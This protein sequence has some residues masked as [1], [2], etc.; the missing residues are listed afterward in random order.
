MLHFVALLWQKADPAKCE[1]AQRLLRRFQAR[2]P[3]WRLACHA[4]GLAALFTITGGPTVDQPYLLPDHVGVVFGRLFERTYSAG[5]VPPQIVIDE[6]RGSQIVTSGGAALIE[7]YW[8]QY[9]AFVHDESARLSWVLRDPTGGVPCLTIEIEGVDIYFQRFEDCEQFGLPTLSI[10]RG[11]LAGRLAYDAVSRR[12]SGLKEISTVLPGEKI[13]HRGG[14]REKTF[15]WN[16]LKIAA[17]GII[18]DPAEA[19]RQTHATVRACVHAWASCF[20]GIL[21]SLSGGLD[22][23]IVLAC[24]S[25]APTRPHLICMNN[26]SAG[27]NSDERVFARLAAQRAGCR[28]LERLRNPNVDMRL[29]ASL[30]RG[31]FPMPSCVDLETAAEEAAFAKSNGLSAQ[32]SG[33]GGDEL[34]HR[35]SRLPPSTDFAYFHGPHARL[36]GLALD[37]AV[38]LHTSFWHVLKV[39]WA[40]G[41]RRRPWKAHELWGGG[42]RP[43]LDPAVIAEA[44]RDPNMIHPLFHSSPR[45]PP[46]KIDL[47]YVLTLHSMRTHNPLTPVDYP[48]DIAPLV[49][50]PLMDLSLR[51]PTYVLTLEGRDRSIARVAFANE[52]PPQIA[53]RRTKGGVEEFLKDLLARNATLIRDLLMDGFLVQEGYLDRAKLEMVLSGE[54]TA[55]NSVSSELMSYLDIEAWARNWCDVRSRAAA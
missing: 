50:Q 36:L 6:R 18:E 49:A 7:E 44:E 13:T 17:S 52:I 22:S 37:D 53:L 46:G 35:S 20:D 45:L 41:L 34:F 5:C 28:L 10:N 19:I 32:F 2:S 27:S 51:I 55:I 16:P 33:E 8:G 39:V 23:A 42:R 30:P 21:L 29:L 24:L 1:A 47:A 54:P 48:A 9:M 38:F 15:L 31:A 43:L 26:Y 40:F 12:E 14:L 4:D 3:Q 11:Y 25:N